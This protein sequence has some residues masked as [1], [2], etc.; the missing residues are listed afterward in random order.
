MFGRYMLG[1]GFAAMFRGMRFG[2]LGQRGLRSERCRF[3]R[4]A[5]WR[6]YGRIRCSLGGSVLGAS[7]EGGRG[8][9]IRGTGGAQARRR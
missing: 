5:F 4:G 6:I 7:R 1:R 3:R 2:D 9:W 8:V